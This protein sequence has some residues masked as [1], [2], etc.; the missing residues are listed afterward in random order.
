MDGVG[1]TRRCHLQTVYEQLVEREKKCKAAEA[2]VAAVLQQREQ[3]LEKR[4]K[5]VG[6]AA[7]RGSHAGSGL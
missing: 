4:H 7:A 3:A 1:L 2:S 6:N 5:Q